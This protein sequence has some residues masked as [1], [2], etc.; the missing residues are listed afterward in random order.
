MLLEL[1]NVSFSYGGTGSSSPLVLEGL[2]LSVNEADMVI[3]RGASGSGKS[4]ILR[5]ICRLQAPAGGVIR[6]RGKAIETITPSTLRSSVCYVPQ[7]PVMM[8]GTV[9]ENLLLPFTFQANRA[10][11]RPSDTV[12]L[13][14]LEN[15]FL[16]GVSPEQ[17]AQKLSVGQKQRLALMRA[18]L[19]TPDL[20]LLDEP[21]SSLDRESAAMVF[22]I[23]ERL[24]RDERM[25]VLLVTHSDYAPGIPDT[26]SYML[27]NRKLEPA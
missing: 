9:R 16:N 21:T 18:L 1:Q 27:A 4:T 5:L 17:S 3:L 2:D 6:F 23:I 8:E 12:L 15:F 19:Q 13:E 20:L 22:S 11:S 14:M 25:T 24:N 10:K 26:R 7:I